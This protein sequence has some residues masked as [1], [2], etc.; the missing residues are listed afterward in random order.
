MRYV[1]FISLSLL[2][3]TNSQAD[4]YKWNDEHGTRQY[5]QSPPRDKSIYIEK[6][7]YKKYLSKSETPS[8]STQDEADEIG[9]S[10]AKRQAATDKAVHQNQ[11]QQLARD[12]CQRAKQSLAALDFGG[13]RLYKD[14]EGNYHRFNTEEKK[15]KREQLKEVILNNCSSS[16]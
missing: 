11:Q 7:K 8:H 14:A 10:N 15:H 5:T 13:N 6:I 2:A 12:S 3:I 1:L 9:R 16:Q 4:I